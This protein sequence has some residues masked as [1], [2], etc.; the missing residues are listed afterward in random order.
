MCPV[1]VTHPVNF[2]CGGNWSTRRKSTTFG[3]VLTNSFHISGL[4]ETRTRNLRGERRLHWQLCHRRP[5][6]S[7]LYAKL[8][9]FSSR[10]LHVHG[11]VNRRIFVISSAVKCWLT[12]EMYQQVSLILMWISR[13]FLIHLS[14]ETQN[15]TTEYEL[16][17]IGIKPNTIEWLKSHNLW[18]WRSLNQH[19]W[20]QSYVS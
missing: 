13:F 15:T 19:F 2:P 14:T 18:T 5:K 1:I 9:Y 8:L 10:E 11:L 16:I 12:M 4:W 20:L 17:I 3:R 7:L 6:P